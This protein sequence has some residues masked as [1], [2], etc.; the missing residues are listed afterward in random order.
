MLGGLIIPVDPRL[1]YLLWLLT[2]VSRSITIFRLLAV[3]E[4]N[5]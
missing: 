4:L 5:C 1:I 2:R 3:V